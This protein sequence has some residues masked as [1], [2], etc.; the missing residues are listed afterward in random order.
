M[1]KYSNNVSVEN[2]INKDLNL[3]SLISSIWREKLI[4]FVFVLLSF[5]SGLTYLKNFTEDQYQATAIFGFEENNNSGLGFMNELR[6]AAGLGLRNDSAGDLLTQITGNNFL[7][8]IILELKLVEDREFYSPINTI[9]KSLVDKIKN[10]V[11]NLLGIKNPEISELRLDEKVN[12]AIKNLRKNNLRIR[13]VQ[14]GGY[15]VQVTSS[16]PHKSALIANTISA[17]FLKYRL[18]NKISKSEKALL[19]LSSKMLQA[20]LDMEKSIQDV[21]DFSLARNI[22]SSTDFQNQATKLNEYREA[23]TKLEKTLGELKSIENFILNND[24]KHPELRNYLQNLFEI[25]PVLKLRNFYL[26]EIGNNVD[27]L[28]IQI[29]F[30]KKNLPNEID[31]IIKSI[32][33]TKTGFNDLEKIAKKTSIDAREHKKLQRTASL[34]TAQYDALSKQFESQSLIEGYKEALGEFYEIASVPIYKSSPN[35]T[36]ILL[37]SVIVGVIFGILTALI[38]NNMSTKIWEITELSSILSKINIISIDFKSRYTIGFLNK[39]I[40][41]SNSIHRY[42]KKDQVSIQ[43]ITSNII[44]TTNA[45]KEKKLIFSVGASGNTIIPQAIALLI[46]M[47]LKLQNKVI[48][49]VDFSSSQTIIEKKIKKVRKINNNVFKNTYLIDKNIN[50]TFFKHLISKNNTID[51]FNSIDDIENNLLKESDIIIRVLNNIEKE[52]KSIQKIQ[53]S[54]RFTLVLNSGKVTSL[55]IFR[56]QSSLESN[57]EKC[58]AAIFIK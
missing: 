49:I 17:R 4:V 28:K 21:E 38:K 26:T 57:L 39:I 32:G 1:T 48:S 15:Q 40:N 7:K 55:D 8:I 23:I 31:R 45:N 36:L 2:D 3:S 9:E 12:E 19:Y 16:D 14:T 33:I 30:I 51:D 52:A 46:A 10:S 44:T 24:I 42:W 35:V 47:Q 27:N 43:G 34:K 5:M 22:L 53:D 18:E 50:Y 25:S 29:N 56:I 20:Q 11:K 58:I 37:L 6:Q 54:D 41:G 13:S